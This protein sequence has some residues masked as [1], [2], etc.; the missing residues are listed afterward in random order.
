MAQ[1]G[2]GMKTHE[3]KAGA[4]RSSGSNQEIKR[5]GQPEVKYSQETTGY[6]TRSSWGAKDESKIGEKTDD[7]IGIVGKSCNAGRA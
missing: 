3:A 2:P 6:H 4:S 5:S 1:A 7:S